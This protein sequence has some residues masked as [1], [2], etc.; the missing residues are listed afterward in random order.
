MKTYLLFGIIFWVVTLASCMEELGNYD[1]E[2]VNSLKLDS[3]QGTTITQFDTLKIKPFIRQTMGQEEEQLEYLWFWYKDAAAE[4]EVLD[5]LSTE[6]NLN[7]YVATE[8]GL[9]HASFQVT[10]K[11][12]G[13][14]ARKNFDVS[15]VADNSGILVLSELEGKANLS[16]LNFAREYFQDVYYA[17]NGEYAGEKPVAIADIDNARTDLHMVVI[18]CQ[19][20]RGGVVVDPSMFRKINVFSDLFYTV[21]KVIHPE[22][23]CSVATLYVSGMGITYD[24]MIND[25]KLYN[26]DFQ[27][28]M[29]E[30]L[31]RPEIY[32]DYK[33]SPYSFLNYNTLMFYDNKNYCFNI[34]KCS[35]GTI[36]TTRLDP[37]PLAIDADPEKM[38]F[39]PRDTKL[40]LVYGGEGWKKEENSAGF[41]YGIFRTPGTTD[42]NNMYCLKFY[43]GTGMSSSYEQENFVAYFKH[44]VREAVQLNEAHAYAISKKDPYLYYACKNKIYSYDLEYDKSK[45]I[46]DTDTVVG[47]GARIDYMYFQPG[48]SPDNSLTM[49][50]ATSIPESSGKTGS[51]HVLGLG[52]NGDV[53]RVDTV[54]Q[55][56]CGKVVGMAYKNR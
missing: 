30:P 28:A 36:N 51:I 26:R 12:T 25:G 3:I 53:V 37:V 7:Y 55:N 14:F 22:T 20:E 40:E 45:V 56:V 23:Y 50:A 52:R 42:L 5:T 34:L 16:L 33:L 18:M 43:I 41:G 15:I 8:P 6:K 47:A 32:G 24:F 13:L 31:F 11:Q 10:D 35:Y 29:Y 38:E 19:D 1:Y 9:Y 39:N 27:N 2:E 48:S 44:P 54:Y 21:P 49:W 17:A 4:L 46:Y